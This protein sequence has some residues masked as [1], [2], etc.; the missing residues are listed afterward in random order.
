MALIMRKAMKANREGRTAGG[1]HDVISPRGGIAANA[2]TLIELKKGAAGRKSDSPQEPVDI[3][4]GA[5]RKMLP[6]EGAHFSSAPVQTCPTPSVYQPEEPKPQTIPYPMTSAWLLSS[7]HPVAA[8][9]REHELT[10]RQRMF[11][12]YYLGPARTNGSDAARLAGYSSKSGGDRTAAHRM[13]TDVHI[14]SA[15]SAVAGLMGDLP[16][17]LEFE[18][19]EGASNACLPRSR[20][21][22]KPVYYDGEKI[23]EGYWTEAPTVDLDYATRVRFR[24]KL[25]AI[26]KGRSSES[27]NRRPFVFSLP[28]AGVLM[29]TPEELDQLIPEEECGT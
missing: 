11:I 18:L 3:G 15:L 19:L 2:E 27:E 26:R 6:V 4:G 17:A 22:V 5:P 8:L 12:L 14:S 10:E 21:Y 16:G 20:V 25:E 1:S 13:L 7:A 24:E 23:A 29:R 28:P 9:L